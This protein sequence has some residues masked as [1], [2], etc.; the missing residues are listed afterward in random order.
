GRR[1]ATPAMARDGDQLP[2]PLPPSTAPP[3]ASPRASQAIGASPS[4][5]P[6]PRVPGADAPRLRRSPLATEANL[7]RSP[8]EPTD[9]RYPINLATALRLSDARPLVVATAQASVWAAEA[10]LQQARVIWIPT[11]NIAAD[12]I[13]HDGGGPDFNKGIMTAPSVNFFYGGA[14]LIGFIS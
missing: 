13:R 10:D 1:P 14:G 7:G 11:L 9:L 4:A 2:S 3:A 12:Y 8:S 6:P 5:I